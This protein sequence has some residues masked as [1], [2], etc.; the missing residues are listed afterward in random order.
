MPITHFLERNAR[1]YRDETALVEI[2]P[3]FEA[4]SRLTWKDYSLMQ[5]IPGEPFR[6]EITWGAFDRAA[7]K[8]ANLLLN[9]V[10]ISD[11]SY[12]NQQKVTLDTLKRIGANARVLTVY[13]KIDKLPKGTELPSGNDV[14]CISAEKN[15][16]IDNLKKK[17]IDML[18]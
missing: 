3:Q 18:F 5:P 13:N 6:R 11:P 16:G 4:S 2:N 12:E 17:I 15:M 1:E 10:D 7:N 14:V 9:V 8:F